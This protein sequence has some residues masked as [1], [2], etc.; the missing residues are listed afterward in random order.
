MIFFL[1]SNQIPHQVDRP[2]GRS[3]RSPLLNQV[4]RLVFRRPDV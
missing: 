2:R 3:P 4:G 1:S